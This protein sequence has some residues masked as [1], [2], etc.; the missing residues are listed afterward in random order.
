[1]GIAATT[2]TVIQ[3]ATSTSPTTVT[4]TTAGSTTSPTA[5]VAVDT[6]ILVYGDC[7]TPSLEPSEIVLTCADY[8]WILEALHWSSWTATRATA[9]GT[10]VYNDCTPNCAEGQHHD[11]PGPR[12]P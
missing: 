2:T 7:Q 10:F 8:G 5:V 12:S 11:V 9:V 4:P 3:S 1:M 6:T